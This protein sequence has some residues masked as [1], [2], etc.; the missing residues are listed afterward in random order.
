MKV[1]VAE[2]ALLEQV[3]DLTYPVWH[4]GLTRRA[5]AQWNRAQLLTPWGRERLQRLALVDASGDVLATLKRYR[6]EIRLDGRAG[7]MCGIGALFTPPD[8]RGLGYATDLVERVLEE[9]RRDG[10]MIGRAH[11]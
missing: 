8:R 3:H 5:Y 4:E 11:V 7:W 10:A 6:Y 1:I 9:A 2:D